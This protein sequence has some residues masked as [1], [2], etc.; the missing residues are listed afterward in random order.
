[1]K[2]PIRM[3]SSRRQRRCKHRDNP[4]EQQNADPQDDVKEQQTGAQL[5]LRRRRQGAHQVV[6]AG[7]RRLGDDEG[8]I[9]AGYRRDDGAAIANPHVPASEG[10][11]MAG[12]SMTSSRKRARLSA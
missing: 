8:Q 3:W 4:A 7:R 6:D 9:G 11:P 2:E 1:M 12:A 5:L 10:Q